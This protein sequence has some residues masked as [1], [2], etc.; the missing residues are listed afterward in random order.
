MPRVQRMPPP[1]EDL[2]SGAASWRTGTQGESRRKTYIRA[3]RDKEGQFIF[4]NAQGDH[5]ISRNGRT[6][7]RCTSKCSAL[8]YGEQRKTIRIG[9]AATAALTAV[10]THVICA[11]LAEAARSLAFLTCNPKHMR[12]CAFEKRRPRPPTAAALPVGAIG[13]LAT[14]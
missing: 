14:M 4:G 10:A 8:T 11:T 9:A 13:A 5:P 7:N 3:E 1:A 6:N 2:D 12:R